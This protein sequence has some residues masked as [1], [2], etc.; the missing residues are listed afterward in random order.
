[1]LGLS[2]R[3]TGEVY[4]AALRNGK[5]DFGMSIGRSAHTYKFDEWGYVS[6]NVYVMH[7][8]KHYANNSYR[9]LSYTPKIK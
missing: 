1:M 2:T 7:C 4:L 3:V 6:L 5:H 8:C 9:R